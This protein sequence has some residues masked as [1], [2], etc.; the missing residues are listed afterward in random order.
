ME[1]RMK[2]GV[3][4]AD[5]TRESAVRPHELPVVMRGLTRKRSISDAV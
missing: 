1:R 3:H 2:I 5:G 4:A